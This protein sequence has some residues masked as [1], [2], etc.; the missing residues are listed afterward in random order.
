MRSPRLAAT[1]PKPHVMLSPINSSLR[2]WRSISPGRGSANSS[3]HRSPSGC[4]RLGVA[5]ATEGR[6]KAEAHEACG[7]LAFPQAPLF[8][9]GHALSAPHQREGVR[10]A[11]RC[12][13]Q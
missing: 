7:G 8:R 5:D 6:V 1:L 12:G 3:P 10:R 2:R 4:G 13:W 9:N 11:E